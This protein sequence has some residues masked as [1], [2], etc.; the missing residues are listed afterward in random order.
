MLLTRVAGRML[1]QVLTVEYIDLET[2]GI[3]VLDT[4]QVDPALVGKAKHYVVSVNSTALAKMV[5]GDL[6]TEFIQT[7]IPGFG[8]DFERLD[9]NRFGAHH[10]TLALADRTGTAQ[11]AGDFIAVIGKPYSAAMAAT[12]V[13][14]C[15]ALA[16][17]ISLAGLSL[18]LIY[19]D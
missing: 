4:A 1:N 7:E 9:G 2:A 12:L 8:L 14:I 5:L 19:R 13:V 16:P 10:R 15:H 3:E 6:V 17:D 18:T 11:P